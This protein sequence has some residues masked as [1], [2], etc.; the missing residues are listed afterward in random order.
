[1]AAKRKAS[2]SRRRVVASAT[3]YRRLAWKAVYAGQGR[4]AEHY[5]RLADALM[6][7]AERL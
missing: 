4:Q 6:R 7:R 1:M 2:A 3:A 5:N